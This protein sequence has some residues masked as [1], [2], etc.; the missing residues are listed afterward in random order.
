[1]TT[2]SHETRTEILKKLLARL[3]RDGQPT[4]ERDIKR[5]FLSGGYILTYELMVGPGKL[6]R[7]AFSSFQLIYHDLGAP[8][9]ELATFTDTD[10]VRAIADALAE[11]EES[12]IESLKAAAIGGL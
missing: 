12:Y 10:E 6:G 11:A 9:L 2:T 4:F 1:M 5:V 7:T 3:Y 8:T